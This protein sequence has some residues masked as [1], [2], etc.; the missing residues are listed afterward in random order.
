MFLRF[1]ILYFNVFYTCDVFLRNL[2]RPE[3]R[4]AAPEYHLTSVGM[5]H[6][7]RGQNEMRNNSFKKFILKFLTT[8]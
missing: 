8:F 1:V 7:I 2:K 5:C 3:R 6:C 4:C